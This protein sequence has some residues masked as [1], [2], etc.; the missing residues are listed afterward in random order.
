MTAR[1]EVKKLTKFIFPE[2]NKLLP[3]ANTIAK[4]TKTGGINVV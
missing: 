1:T 4:D 2:T 3:T